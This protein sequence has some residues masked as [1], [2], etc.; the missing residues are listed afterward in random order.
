MHFR[1]GDIF[2]GDANGN[3]HGW[4]VQPPASYY[5][6]A[7]DYA[8]RQLGVESACLVFQDRTNPAVDCVAKELAARGVPCR[9]Q[10]TDLKTDLS[11]LLGATHIVPSYGTFCEA[12]ALLSPHC[13]SYFGF[14]RLSCLHEVEG[15]PQ[16]RVDQ[17]LRA[18][19]VRTFLIDDVADRYT[20]QKRWTASSEQLDLMKTYPRD[21]LEL[22]EIGT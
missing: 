2:V 7:F 5:L 19:G 3:I 4:Y 10:S 22:T 9:L 8:Q 1:G 15:F 16:S 11:C 13:E 17:M 21:M 12:I 14:R 20:S 18:M 6:K